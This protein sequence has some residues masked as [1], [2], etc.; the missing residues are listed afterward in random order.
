M[1]LEVMTIAEI[2]GVFCLVLGAYLVWGI[3]GGIFALGLALLY[4]ANG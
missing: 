2:A 1:R 4:E 3:G